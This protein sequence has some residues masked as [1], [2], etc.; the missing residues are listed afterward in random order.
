[1][2]I[3]LIVD[4]GQKCFKATFLYEN[5]VTHVM[6]VFPAFPV[7]IPGERSRHDVQWLVDVL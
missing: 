1:M 3:F 5:F 2:Y 6:L 4:H 7:S